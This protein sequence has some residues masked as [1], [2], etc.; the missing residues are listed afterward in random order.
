MPEVYRMLPNAGADPPD[1]T[2]D[3]GHVKIASLHTYP[4]KGCHR[5]DH[6]EARAEPWGLAGDRRWMVVDADGIG[7]TQRITPA[8]T[9]LRAVPVP[10]G[11]V[12]DAPGMPSLSVAE[13]VDGPKE[14]VRVFRSKQPVPARIA[15]ATDWFSAF[16]GRPAR[17]VWLGDPTARAIE[18]H[19]EPGDRVSFADGYPVLLTNAASLAAVN[20]WL[21]E[22]GDEPIPMTR[23]RPNIV[24]SAAGPWAEDEWLDHR[25]RI[26]D[27]AFRAAKSCARCV[28]TTI[29]QETGETGRQPL[30]ILGRYRRSRSDLLFGINLIPDVGAGETGIIRVGEAVLR[31]A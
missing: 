22:D 20:D 10:A 31:L 27:V 3:A 19:A 4:V 12:L 17:L 15:P 16:L 5:L 6:D 14:F 8:L 25:L 7:I 13:P 30:R 24:V 9:G 11:L 21:V 18:T 29:D 2:C 26:G 28:V 1:R 23:F